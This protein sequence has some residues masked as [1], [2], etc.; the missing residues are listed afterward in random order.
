MCQDVNKV[1]PKLSWSYVVDARN[2]GHPRRKAVGTE[3]GS[4]VVRVKASALKALTAEAWLPIFSR[5]VSEKSNSKNK[6]RRYT[7]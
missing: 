4:R 6:E 3:C 7:Q 1:K 2:M 5:L